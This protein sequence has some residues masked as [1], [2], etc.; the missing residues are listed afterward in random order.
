MHFYLHEILR[1]IMHRYVKNRK[2]GGNSWL[3]GI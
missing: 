2:E 3:K 1:V